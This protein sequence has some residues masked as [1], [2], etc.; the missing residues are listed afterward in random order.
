MYFLTQRPA[1]L[2]FDLATAAGGLFLWGRVCS[3]PAGPG[4][5]DDQHTHN[6]PTDRANAL[7]LPIQSPDLLAE[8]LM[9]SH[10]LE[11]CNN[12]VN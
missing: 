6:L 11:V 9:C 10:I 2:V 1:P 7:H 4:D 8:A 3:D 5:R 12:N